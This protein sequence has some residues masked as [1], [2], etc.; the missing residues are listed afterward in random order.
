MTAMKTTQEVA[1]QAKVSRPMIWR[2][3]R[4]LG[5]EPAKYVGNTAIWT[6][7]QVRK[8]VKP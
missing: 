8:L 3:A 1:D 2:R 7:E 5:L 6:A 4:K